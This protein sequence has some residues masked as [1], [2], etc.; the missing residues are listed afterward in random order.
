[1]AGT[2]GHRAEVVMLFLVC[3]RYEDNGRCLFAL[4]VHNGVKGYTTILG[5]CGSKVPPGDCG[6]GLAFICHRWKTDGRFL[7][8]IWVGDGVGFRVLVLGR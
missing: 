8:V 3:Y 2:H 6:A 7:L 4:D 5:G 1:M